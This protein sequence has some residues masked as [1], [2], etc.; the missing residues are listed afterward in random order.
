MSREQQKR[1]G[2]AEGKKKEHV[3]DRECL[4]IS[5]LEAGEKRCDLPN[6][7]FE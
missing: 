2:S 4:C 7:F 1:K 3:S 5:A 6:C